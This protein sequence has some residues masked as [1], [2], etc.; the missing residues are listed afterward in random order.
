[1]PINKKISCNQIQT[2]LLTI[3]FPFWVIFMT[4]TK[5][6]VWLD[7]KCQYSLIPDLSALHKICLTNLVSIKDLRCFLWKFVENVSGQIKRLILQNK[8][9]KW[10]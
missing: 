5:L 4:M 1:M 8:L 2:D 7:L 3:I 6:F 9:F 10:T